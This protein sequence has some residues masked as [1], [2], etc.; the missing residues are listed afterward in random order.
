MGL[1]SF[2][3]SRDSF[4]HPFSIMYKGSAKFRTLPG[5]VVTIMIQAL[6][7][8]YLVQKIVQLV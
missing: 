2:L 7:V 4:G 1:T 6:L 8:I 5:A 3:L